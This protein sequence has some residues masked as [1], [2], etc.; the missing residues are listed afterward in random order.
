[1]I[2]SIFLVL[3]AGLSQPF[4]RNWVLSPAEKVQRSG[5]LWFGYCTESGPWAIYKSLEA[6][7]S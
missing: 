7:A 6:K 3:A 4:L 5:D 2:F 1:M